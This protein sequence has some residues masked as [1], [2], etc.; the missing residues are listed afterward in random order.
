MPKTNEVNNHMSKV[1]Y[2]NAISNLMHVICYVVG[3]ASILLLEWLIYS[4]ATRE[5]FIGK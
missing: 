4:K 3:Q 5:L 2:A 1:L